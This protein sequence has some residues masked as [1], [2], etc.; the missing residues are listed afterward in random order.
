MAQSI[1][2][3]VQ[4]TR[5]ANRLSQAGQGAVPQLGALRAS[6]VARLNPSQ[7]G[8]HCFLIAVGT[9]LFQHFNTCHARVYAMNMMRRV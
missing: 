7:S 9:F 8:H 1:P 6:S 5:C 2:L 3:P 4:T